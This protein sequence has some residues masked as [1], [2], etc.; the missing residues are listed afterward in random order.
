MRLGRVI[1]VFAMQAAITLAASAPATVSQADASAKEWE[2]LVWSQ[3]IAG[4]KNDY[5]FESIAKPEP[6][7]G[8][9][10]AAFPT[11]CA[12]G[13][14]DGERGASPPGPCAARFWAQMWHMPT[15]TRSEGSAKSWRTHCGGTKEVRRA[16]SSLTARSWGPGRH[17]EQ[18][19]GLA[20]GRLRGVRHG[21]H[22]DG[23]QLVE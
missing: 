14:R 11:K 12:S 2:S 8:H 21:K 22:R 6:R 18:L 1:I 9:Q 17:L 16:P 23:V 15:C 4:T 20:L 5:F 13:R 3:V 10:V 7:I 19:A